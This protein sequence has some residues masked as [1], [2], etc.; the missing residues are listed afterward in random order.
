MRRMCCSMCLTPKDSL[1]GCI[2]QEHALEDVSEKGG[3]CVGTDGDVCVRSHCFD[4]SVLRRN[5]N[6]LCW[7]LF[8]V[9]CLNVDMSRWASVRLSSSYL[10]VHAPTLQVAYP[11]HSFPTTP[12]PLSGG[13]LTNGGS[14]LLT[15]LL[16]LSLRVPPQ[17]HH[18]STPPPHQHSPVDVSRVTILPVSMTT[19]CCCPPLICLSLPPSLH[20]HRTTTSSPFP[21]SQLSPFF[22]HTVGISR[23]KRVTAR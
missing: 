6:L 2:L 10:R 14:R 1:L 12:A 11:P 20:P 17:H 18:N 7:G 9:T 16:T 3:Q 8:T 4:N 22:P 21:H 19:T 15:Y 5:W 13:F 23:S